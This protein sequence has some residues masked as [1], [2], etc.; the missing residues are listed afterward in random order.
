MSILKALQKKSTESVGEIAPRNIVQF[1]R[2]ARRQTTPPELFVGEDVRIGTPSSAFI[3]QP[4]SSV[5]TAL[6]DLDTEQTAGAKLNAETLTRSG[7]RR[8]PD[9]VSWTVDAER[10]EPRLVAITQPHSSYCEEYRSLRTHVLHKGQRNQLKSIVIASVN[11]SEGKSITAMNL[12][13]MLAQ[14]DGVK[15]LIIDADLRMPSLA[16]YLGIETDK[17]LSDILVEDAALT[18]CIIKLEPS[19][20]YILPGGDARQDVA[21]LIS[22]PRFK[23]I[24]TEAREIFDFIIIDAPPL[25]IFTDATVLIEQA[26][27]AILVVRANRTRYSVIDRVLDPLP[28]DRFLGVVL[29]QSEDVM[30]E[31]HYSYGYY[32]YRR[33]NDASTP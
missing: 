23:D 33:L 2:I 8:L 12:A 25:G 1:D 4:G 13:W 7:V 5:G 17:G 6:P 14:T 10:V 28:K 32:N 11:P 31:S 9:F 22:G 19:G 15:A 3:G 21:E 27:A 20:L 26:D 16:D 30:A 29:N 18:D 24:L